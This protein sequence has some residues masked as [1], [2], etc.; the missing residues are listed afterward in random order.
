MKK[1][2]ITTVAVW[3]ITLFLPLAS[4][5][6]AASIEEQVFT[7]LAQNISTQQI[8][9]VLKVK[10]AYDSGDKKALVQTI[11]QKTTGISSEKSSNPIDFAS[12]I[13]KGE[14]TKRIQD[15]VGAYEKEINILNALLGLNRTLSPQVLQE[16][17][18][19]IGAP[20]NYRR[21]INMTATAYAPG[22][23]DN[24]KWNDKTFMGG[25]VQKGVAAVDPKVIPMG[26]KLWVEGY[27]EALAVD[28]GSAIKGNRIDL[29]FDNRKEALNYGIQNIKVYVLNEQ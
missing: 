11:I 8:Q 13:V 23:E 6:R 12:E 5:V 21:V 29:A 20:Q 4:P 19:L 3:I 22:V 18:S 25:F 7:A 2:L 14:V 16:N 28:Q 1:L 10:Q 24:G 26:T 15:K 27:G 9:D 17:N